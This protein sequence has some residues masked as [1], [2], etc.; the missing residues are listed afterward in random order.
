MKKKDLKWRKKNYYKLNEINDKQHNVFYWGL[1]IGDWG[2][3]N[4]DW[5]L[6]PIPNPQ[7]PT[8]HSPP[9]KKKHK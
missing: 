9:Q 5:G 2:L 7:Y 4:G 1:G 3:G 8:A 6:G